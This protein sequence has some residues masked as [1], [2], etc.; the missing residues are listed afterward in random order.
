MVHTY[1]LHISLYPKILYIIDITL[2]H[3]HNFFVN[4]EDDLKLQLTPTQETVPDNHPSMDNFDDDTF[5]LNLHLT[6]SQD[7]NETRNEPMTIG[8]EP[9]TA[10]S[11]EESFLCK[12]NF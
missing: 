5:S 12:Y 2:K 11:D 1:K 3:E 6:P 9:E 8:N 4:T 10:D 7:T